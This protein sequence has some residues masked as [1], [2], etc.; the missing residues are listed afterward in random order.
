MFPGR[1]GAG[2]DAPAVAIIEK[3]GL[4]PYPD[5]AW[6]AWKPGS[7]AANSFVNVNAIH[8][9]KDGTLW[10]IDT[11]SPEFGGD[12]LPGGAKVVN[13]SLKTNHIARIYSLGPVVLPGSY[14]DDIRIN[15]RHAYLTDAGKTPGIIVLDLVSGKGRRVLEDV[16]A[17]RATPGRDI[18]LD[19]KTIKAPDGKPLIVNADPLELNA[20]GKYFYFGPLNGPW[21]RIETHLLDDPSQ[22]AAALREALEVWADLPPI[23]GAVMDVDGSLYFTELSTNSL[24]RRDPDGKITTIVSD[25]RLH[26]VD[27]PFIDAQ[28]DIWLPVPQL[29]RAPPFNGG[30]SRMRQPITLYRYQLPR[31]S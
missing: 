16:D 30:V 27:A 29:D 9:G 31:A 26:W 20:D 11:G 24:K 4:A 7:D 28:R 10:V 23:G 19:G 22:P 14:V 6:N 8:L 3:D 17:V 2:G 25:P 12:P 13:I 21:N 18:I 15:G 5:V 1:D